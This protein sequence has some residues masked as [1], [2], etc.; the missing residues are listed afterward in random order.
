[1]LMKSC[2][3]KSLPRRVDFISSY[4]EAHDFIRA[5]G[6]ISLARAFTLWR[7]FFVNTAQIRTLIVIESRRSLFY[8]K[9]PDPAA[10][11]EW[12]KAPFENRVPTAE[13]FLS[14]C[15]ERI[16]DNFSEPVI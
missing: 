6:V 11:A 1:M 10:Q 2:R 13:E 8:T 9:D 14:W 4:A 12:A 16:S 15:A 7:I 5:A 3:M